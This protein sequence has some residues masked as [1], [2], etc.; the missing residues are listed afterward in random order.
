LSKESPHY[1][2]GSE[3]QVTELVNTSIS[4]IIPHMGREQMLIDTLQSI[5]EQ[6]YDLTKIEVI[7][8]TKNDQ[9]SDAVTSIGQTLKLIVEHASQALTISHQRNMGAG[10]AKGNYFAFL[11]ADVHLSPNWIHAML[12]I[13]EQNTEIKLVS[14]VQEN[15]QNAP[16]LEQLRT[17]LS[18]AAI[19]CEVE[20]LPGRNLLLHA[21]TFEKSGG[22]PEHLLTCEDYVFT[23]SVSKLGGLYYSSAS[24]YIHL[25]EDKAF[26]PMAKKEVWRGQSNIAS[27]RGRKIP[28]SEWP[29]FIAP[30]AFTFGMLFSLIAFF[31]GTNQLAVLFLLGACTIIIL[32]SLRLRRISKGK[33]GLLTIGI[34]YALYFPARTWGTIKGIHTH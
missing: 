15:S 30:P 27:L 21:D 19:D 7:V 3:N 13:L 4:F 26:W 24:R 22:F 20:F 2:S 9:L 1:Q 11:D 34:F 14:A 12:G 17:A 8:V 18:N 28:L 32:Y 31:M 16:P 6:D 23:Q 25:G 5:C 33:P 29:S 10:I